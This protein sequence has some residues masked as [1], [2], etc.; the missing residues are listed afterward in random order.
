MRA[1]TAIRSRWVDQV[2]EY[3]HAEAVML[4]RVQFETRRFRVRSSPSERLWKVG[5]TGF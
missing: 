1:A 5:T 2:I 3:P 4:N